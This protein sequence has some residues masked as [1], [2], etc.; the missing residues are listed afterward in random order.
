MSTISVFVVVVCTVAA[1]LSSVGAVE[2]SPF[3]LWSHDVAVTKRYDD[4]VAFFG[5]WL[6]LFRVLVL[7]SFLALF[8]ATMLAQSAVLLTVLTRLYPYA[9]CLHSQPVVQLLRHDGVRLG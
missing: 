6:F 4:L 2:S 7:P 1:I 9:L 5:F 8:L 3:F